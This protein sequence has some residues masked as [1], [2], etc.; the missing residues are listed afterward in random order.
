[1][2][3]SIPAGPIPTFL[4]RRPTGTPIA[5]AAK[6]DPDVFT[7]AG[8]P[9]RDDDDDFV[10]DDNV[11]LPELSGRAKSK[12]IGRILAAVAKMKPGQSFIAP[13]SAGYLKKLFRAKNLKACVR[14][15]DGKTRVWKLP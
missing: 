13:A 10:I 5:V 4:P 11:P 14:K 15:R 1:M 8:P 6:Q 2:T 9:P 12:T 3:R 7:G